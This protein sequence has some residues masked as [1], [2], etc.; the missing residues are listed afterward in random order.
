MEEANYKAIIVSYG[1]NGIPGGPV[2]QRLITPAIRQ[3]AEDYKL[4]R[5]NGTSFTALTPDEFDGPPNRVAA[6][7]QSFGY[8]DAIPGGDKIPGILDPG[9]D[10]VFMP[11][12]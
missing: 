4:Y 7:R 3:A 6:L 11:L 9:S 5:Q 8:L 1:K 10:D 12:R 2:D